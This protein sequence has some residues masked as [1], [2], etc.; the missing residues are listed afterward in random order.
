MKRTLVDVDKGLE[1]QTKRLYVYS[2]ELEQ[3]VVQLEGAQQ[4]MMEMM[5]ELQAKVKEL[6]KRC[7]KKNWDWSEYYI[8]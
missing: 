3:R 8:G 1:R 6:E 5:K 2:N 4:D 7:E